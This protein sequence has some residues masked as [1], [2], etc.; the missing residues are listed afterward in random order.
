M[1]FDQGGAGLA[2]AAIVFRQ[3][4]EAGALA[5]RERA[6]A[7]LTA[8]GPGKH[9]GGVPGSLRRGAVAGGL[10]TAG[11][12]LV[13]GALEELAQGKDLLQAPVM[14]GQQGLQGLAQTAGPID[15]SG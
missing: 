2:E 7:G 11:L 12:E 6:Q 1:Q 3:L 9:G 5:G 10:A 13:D 14:V 4:A 15:W 8:L